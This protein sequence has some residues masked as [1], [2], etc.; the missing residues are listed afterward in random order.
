[1]YEHQPAAPEKE[2]KSS[3][4]TVSTVFMTES[5][6]GFVAAILCIVALCGVQPGYMIS[7]ATIVLGAT[8]LFDAASLAARYRRLPQHVSA[9]EWALAGLIAGMIVA[10]IAGAIGVVFGVLALWG[11]GT[12]ALL[13]V[14]ALVFG[15][16]L[17]LGT[18]LVFR[19]NSFEREAVEPAAVSGFRA[20]DVS[21]WIAGG[22]QVLLGVSAIM[23][24]IL[25]LTDTAP[26]T[27][28]A[29]GLLLVS[30][31]AFIT[32]TVFCTRSMLMMRRF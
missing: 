3:M 31:A 7:I 11:L 23:L 9:G 21:G 28:T 30:L 13:A 15:V 25:A 29:V 2:R 24:A 8:L 18:G 14:A 20:T 4:K 17:I 10:L 19:L 1:M 5:I 32:G 26:L 22:L 12:L 16:A 27:N 6:G